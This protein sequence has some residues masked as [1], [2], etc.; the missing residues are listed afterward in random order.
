VET[1]QNRYLKRNI[2]IKTTNLKDGYRIRLILTVTIRNPAIMD[3]IVKGTP[4]DFTI[5]TKATEYEDT[6]VKIGLY[7]QIFGGGNLI[8]GNIKAREELEKL[9]NEFWT[10]IEE[11]IATLTNA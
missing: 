2:K 8:L 3:I 9:E 11:T 4:N 5:E 10:T 6:A 7:T 1:I